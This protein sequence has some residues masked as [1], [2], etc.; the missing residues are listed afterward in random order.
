MKKTLNIVAIFLFLFVMLFTIPTYAAETLSTINVTTSKEKILP[1][2]E[3][4]VKVDFG[5]GLSSYTVDIAYDKNLFDYVSAEGGTANDNGTRVRVYYFD[6]AGGSN[7]RNGISVTF[8]AKT[9]LTTENPTS[10]NVTAE[11]LANV[12]GIVTTDYTDITTAIVK[13]VTVGK[14]TTTVPT[15]NTTTENTTTQ[16]NNNQIA[17]TT[18]PKTMPK[19][20]GTVYEAIFTIIAVLAVIYFSLKTKI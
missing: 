1:G 14:A 6:Q 5:I 20:G 4:T 8:K 15:E 10:F 16:P 19:T 11:G 9:G 13:N 12:N 2:E 18:T 3:V 17:N 7:K